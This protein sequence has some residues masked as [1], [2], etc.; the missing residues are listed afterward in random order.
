MDW[1]LLIKNKKINKITQLCT[2]CITSFSLRAEF[3]DLTMNAIGSSPALTLGIP[4]TAASLIS[5]WV[6]NNDS[7]SAGATYSKNE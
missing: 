6:N 4:I 1:T 2:K 5:G 3:G 7:N